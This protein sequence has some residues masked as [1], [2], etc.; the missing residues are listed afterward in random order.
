MRINNFFKKQLTKDIKNIFNQN[1]KLIFIHLFILIA[2]TI[3]DLLS[4]H[5]MKS[6][7]KNKGFAIVEDGKIVSY[8][9]PVTRFF[10]I[11]YVENNG[12][13]FGL[14]NSSSKV[15]LCLIILVTIFVSLILIF[16]YLQS[17]NEEGTVSK[18]T[19][20]CLVFALAGAAGNI[21]DR[22][23]NYAVFDFLDIHYLSYHWPSFNLA[24]CFISLAV[25]IILFVNFFNNENIR[26][27][28]RTK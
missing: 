25:I 20:I 11:V 21:I 18:V 10:N 7:L 9:Y 14:F 13:T 12:I 3:S 5:F 8:L 27:R 28:S 24:D 15:T 2:I 4:K 6:F 19:R 17:F 23:F 26:H 1:K 22:I 16:Y